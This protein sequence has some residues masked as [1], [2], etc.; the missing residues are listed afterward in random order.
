M[1]ISRQSARPLL[2]AA[3]LCSLCAGV[4]ADWPQWGGPERNGAVSGF[5]APQ[6]WP[7]ELKQKWKET[8]GA[9][10]ATPALVGDRLYVFTRQGADEVLSCLDAGSGKTLW[11]DKHDPGVTVQGAPGAHPGP[12]SSP[13]VA[14]GKVVTLG[15]S[16]VLSCVDAGTGKLAWRK[17]FKNDFPATWPQF[18]TSTSPL[19]ADGLC[20][21]Q[22]GGQKGRSGES[23]GA[24]MAFDLASGN[25]KWKAGT[26][27]P[28]YASP[29]VMT[30][31]GTRMVVAMTD[32]SM[33]GVSLA[34]GKELWKVPTMKQRMA[35]NAVS[36]IVD[37]DTI[38]YTGQGKGTRALQVQRQEDG[39]ATKE[40]WSNEKVGSV[41]STPVLKDGYL[42]GLSDRG[43][44]FCL[45][46]KS[47]KTLWTDTTSHGRG[48]GSIVDAGPVL[49]ALTQKAELIVFKPS[50]TEFAKVAEY[51]VSDDE[52]YT[53]PVV[54][55]DRVYI[56]D[57]DSV[58]LWT[59][60]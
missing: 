14:E 2:G 17:E 41:F 58:A 33:L 7:K 5:T 29:V 47:G 28:A 48:F 4:R 55:A 12:R 3:V 54:S 36:P 23:K 59:I 45:D 31:G 6:S 46:A 13:A 26:D 49:L 52:T 40:L 21:A 60:E 1:R 30:V 22:L 37:G 15:V 20:I 57:K 50:E 24:V 27:S 44:F 8:V 18:Y 10:D 32:G 51:K 42:F 39:F 9:G 56:K 11:Q 35:Q 43:N 34:D 16:E 53:Y 19:I 38:I 25:V